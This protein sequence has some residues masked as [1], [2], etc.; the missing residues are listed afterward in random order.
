[1]NNAIK[2]DGMP[3]NQT[4]IVVEGKLEKNNILKSLFRCFPEI[5]I[6]IENVH[7]YE[8]DIYDLYHA[9]EEEYGALWFEEN[10]EVDIPYLVS[11][12]FDIVPSLEKRN[13]TNIILMFDY[14]HHDNFYSDEKIMKMQ[15][16]FS[17]V[18]DEG[19]LYINYPMIES[20]YHYKSFPDNEYLF[21][22]IPVTCKP[23]SAYKNEV[24]EESCILEYMNLYSKLVDMLKAKINLSDQ[25]IEEGASALLS[26]GTDEGL[27]KEIEK[28]TNQTHLS[29]KNKNNL[30]FSI[31]NLLSR[32]KYIEQGISYW[33]DIRTYIGQI[34][35]DNII[36]ADSI[37]KETEDNETTVKE[38]YYAIDWASVLEKQNKLS[39]DSV[40]G[41]IMVLCTCITFL[42]EYK[43]Y[44]KLSSDR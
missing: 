1:M 24:Q 25:I 26:A 9:I 43:F 29:E 8:S 35:Q 3:R 20:L 19:L 18:E 4:L 17:S 38:K 12:R 7:V 30:K 6:R 32:Q 31:R 27:E 44:W 21:R 41:I 36:K 40:N 34:V 15:K 10:M 22:S 2:I 14:E 11:K 5:P 33:E 39:T 23:G 16:H 28:F 42:G 37:Q 13:F